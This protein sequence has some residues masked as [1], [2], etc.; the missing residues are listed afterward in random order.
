MGAMY[1]TE[2]PFTRPDLRGPKKEATYKKEE[3]PEVKTGIPYLVGFLV[4]FILISLIFSTW[5]Y[6]AGLCGT[7]IGLDKY[8]DTSLFCEEDE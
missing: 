6:H 4:A 7:E 5:K 1:P 2:C 3:A 8:I